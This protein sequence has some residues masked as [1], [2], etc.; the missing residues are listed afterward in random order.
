[1]TK[2]DQLA[3]RLFSGAKN[4]GAEGWYI[5]P[6]IL[7]REFDI[8]TRH[9][10]ERLLG[11]ARE[12]LISLD[13][14]TYNGFHPFSDWQNT[15]EFFEHANN[16]GYVRVKLLAAGDEYLERLHEIEH[17]PIGFQANVG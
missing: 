2:Y 7:A 11:W 16:V 1:M 8:E 17:R 15:D 4:C 9:V 14:Y 12:G 13:V 3:Q 5:L 6:S 10:R